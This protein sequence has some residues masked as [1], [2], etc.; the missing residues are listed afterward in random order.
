MA[1]VL[2]VSLVAPPI[3]AKPSVNPDNDACS[4]AAAE[5]RLKRRE[6]ALLGPS[7]AEDHARARAYKCRVVMG[8]A[9]VAT[10][11]AQVLAA[12]KTQAVDTA[13]AWSEPFVIPVVGITSVL[14]RNG[15]VLF[16]S[17][18]PTEYRNP[19]ASNT[20]VA[21]VWDPVTRTGHSITPPENIWCGGQTILS[22]GRVYVAGGN[23]RYPDPNA[24]PGQTNFE[25]SLSNYTF[26]P[27]TETWTAQ[28]DMATGRWYP[29]VTKLADNSVVITSGLDQTGAG[30]VTDVVELFT[31]AASIDGVGT[32]STVSFHDPNGLY[33]YQYLV[34]SGQ[35]LQAGPSATNTSLLTPNTWSWSD[36]PNML[37]SHNG[38]GNGILYTDASVTPIKQVIMIAGGV[39]QNTAI[40]NNEWFDVA[41]PAAGWTQFPQWLQAR[42][43]ANTVILPD[44]TLFTVGGNSSDMDYDNPLFESELY[45]KP[46]NDP[47]G[48]W[49]QMDPNTIQAA[50][51]SSAILLPDATVLLSQD[52]MDP[53]AA[54]THQ[55][56]VYSPAYLFKGT[57]PN[58]INVPSAL[59]L[60]Q[61]FSVT[62]SVPNIA[63]VALV[64]P[65]AVTHANDMHQ[66]F[67]KLQYAND[68][69]G[70]LQVTM[71]A[72][73]SLVPP[74]YYM[75]F[76][77]DSQGIPSVAEF[78]HIS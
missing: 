33:P 31:P 71:P 2:G 5:A 12:A 3:G 40:S 13:G 6:T 57:R 4:N 55:A 66:R 52:D 25:G 28:P 77:I 21:Y 1:T 46:A 43:N 62:A 67:I 75:L 30:N 16:W 22:D 41:N 54:S 11:D 44:G 58:I 38:W 34:S 56:Q 65:G 76:I 27:I 7:H 14:L 26:N 19:D 50:Y 32:I 35:L 18:E 17:Y 47:N 69:S 15:K 63:S 51:H 48:T 70:N 29:T 78:V 23:L 24:A 68:G 36:I 9:K 49:V 72:S 60:G 45:N 8:L 53:L 42:H 20:G 37:S 73:S 10:P 39:E 74:G 59:S 61:T 64:A